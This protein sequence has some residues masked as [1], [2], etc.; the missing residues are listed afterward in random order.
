MPTPG[1]HGPAR[2][3]NIRSVHSCT[4]RTDLLTGRRVGLMTSEFFKVSDTDESVMVHDEMW[5]VN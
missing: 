5:K 3:P 1:G 2:V 4:K